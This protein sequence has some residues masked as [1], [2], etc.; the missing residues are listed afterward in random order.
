MTVSLNGKPEVR[1]LATTQASEYLADISPDG[2]LVAYESTGAGGHEVIV[3]TFPDKGGHWQVPITGV[4]EPMWRADGRELFFVSANDEL[5][6]VDVDRSGGNVRFGPRRVLFRPH[7]L[8]NTF[9]RYAP[10]PDGQSFVV[11]TAVSPPPGQQMTVLMNWRSG[12]PK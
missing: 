3:E 9:R 6:A 5:C 8:P 10:L 11:L 2:R 7:N 4:S 1:H 12:L